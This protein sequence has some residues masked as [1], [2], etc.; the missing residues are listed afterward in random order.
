MTHETFPHNVSLGRGD[1]VGTI[2]GGIALLKF[3]R[4]TNV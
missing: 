3:E 1:D 2:F 4:A